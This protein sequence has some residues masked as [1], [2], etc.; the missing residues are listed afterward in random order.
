MKIRCKFGLWWWCILGFTLVTLFGFLGRLF[1]VFD[2][3][4]HFR[5]QIFQIG[6]VLIGIAL[7]K[8]WNQ[9]AAVLAVLVC[10]NYA[11]VLPFYLGKPAPA[12]GRSLRAMLMNINALNGN[13]GRVLDAI[14]QFN[15]DVLLLEEVTPKREY[16]LAGLN[17]AY[18]YRIA[19]PRNDCFG[20]MLLSKV[21]LS[22]TNVV[23]LGD[24]GVPSILAT[25]HFPQGEVSLIGTHPVPPISAEYSKHRNVQLAAL[26]Q[27]ARTQK[28]PVLLMGDLNASP[29]SPYFTRLLRDSGLKNSMRGFG[30]QPS[31]PANIQFLRIPIDQILYSPEIVIHRRAVGVDTGSDHL[32]VI[33]DFSLR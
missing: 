33:V 1:W 10:L 7:W 14:G 13:T 2:L 16:E 26:P 22:Q 31:W 8:R 11:F 20:I 5:V 21:P 4:S 15:P 29:W 18:P 24:A 12:E 23:V 19:V 27:I 28:Y 32:P 6:L 30:F 9:Q 3:F 25:A 17:T